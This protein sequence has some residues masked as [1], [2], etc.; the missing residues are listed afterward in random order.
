MWGLQTNGPDVETDSRW[1]GLG[2]AGFRTNGFDY[3]KVD[4]VAL[5]VNTFLML[6]S[7]F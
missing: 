4:G 6:T 2:A 1:L 3:L 5:L 7:P